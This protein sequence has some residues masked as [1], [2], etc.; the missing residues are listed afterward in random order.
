MAG[1]KKQRR[2]SDLVGQARMFELRQQG[3]TFA[4]IAQRMQVTR[5]AVH[6]ALLSFARLRCRLCAAELNQAAARA[7]DRG[8][9]FCLPCLAKWPEASFAEHLRAFRI[10]AALTRQDLARLTRVSVERLANYESG[11]ARSTSWADQVRLFKA[12]GVR[13]VAD[14]RATK[15]NGN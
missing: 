14:G 6:K 11:F 12:L 5:Q 9:A 3:L 10:A 8:K 13:L 4:E 7:T 2:L 15:S 1:A